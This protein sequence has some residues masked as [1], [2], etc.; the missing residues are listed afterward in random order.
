[1]EGIEIEAI[2]SNRNEID[3]WC[4]AGNE[5]EPDKIWDRTWREKRSKLGISWHELRS[6][7]LGAGI[8]NVLDDNLTRNEVNCLIF[9]LLVQLLAVIEI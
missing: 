1:M 4:E 6:K 5:I 7:M 3:V 8:W 2:G 9:Q